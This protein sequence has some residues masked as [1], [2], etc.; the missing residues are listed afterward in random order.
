MISKKQKK[1]AKKRL[2]D[3]LEIF[4]KIYEAIEDKNIKDSLIGIVMTINCLAKEIENKD[5][6][7]ILEDMR[8]I[9][10]DIEKANEQNN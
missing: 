4:E 3:P 7:D 2:K 6:L 8:K 1:A 10:I 5:T 9:F